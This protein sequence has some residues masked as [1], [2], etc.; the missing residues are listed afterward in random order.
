MKDSENIYDVIGKTEPNYTL[1]LTRYEIETIL[2]SLI[3]Y[4]AK[5]DQQ[6]KVSNAVYAYLSTVLDDNG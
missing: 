4:R 6:E 2:M 5:A 1:K 3:R